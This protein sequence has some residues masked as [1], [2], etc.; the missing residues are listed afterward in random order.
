MDAA[1]QNQ[2]RSNASSVNVLYSGLGITW[3]PRNSGYSKDADRH[4]HKRGGS[5]EDSEPLSG[6]ILQCPETMGADTCAFTFNRDRQSWVYLVCTVHQSSPKRTY[7]AFRVG[8]Q[9]PQFEIG[10]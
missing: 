1:L 4:G 9:V 2:T 8:D 10:E 3:A 6:Y 5:M 7:F